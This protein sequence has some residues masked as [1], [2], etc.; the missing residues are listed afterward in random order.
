VAIRLLIALCL[1]G[2]SEARSAASEI[3]LRLPFLSST[4]DLAW[5]Q[6]TDLKSGD[7]Y[8]TASPQVLSVDDEGTLC[9]YRIPESLQGRVLMNLQTGV[10]YSTAWS[11]YAKV[12]IDSPAEVVELR[13]P[14]AFGSFEIVLPQEFY[15]KHERGKLDWSVVMFRLDEVTGLPDPYITF[16]ANVFPHVA[17]RGVWLDVP[18]LSPGKF[19]LAVESSDGIH[20]AYQ[21]TVKIEESNLGKF[22][23]GKTP[24]EA[25]KKTDKKR[26]RWSLGKEDVFEGY[27]AIGG[28]KFERD[29]KVYYLDK[30]G[31]VKK[32]D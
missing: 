27:I 19:L 29:E 26:V 7:T 17:D 8:N 25:L 2:L 24:M 9:V 12:V 28:R 30:E 15:D 21:R 23:P 18:F 31:R 20:R 32:E 4:R 10:G 1:L 11:W 6:I 14:I 3:K 5:L 16:F 13:P 22:Q